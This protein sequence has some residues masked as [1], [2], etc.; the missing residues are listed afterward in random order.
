M[1]DIYEEYCKCG[2]Q[3]F[4]GYPDDKLP[5]RCIS[6]K[7]EDM[8]P[9]TGNICQGINKDGSPCQSFASLGIDK[10]IFCSIHAD[11]GMKNLNAKKCI[12]CNGSIASLGKFGDKPEYCA[13][14][15]PN[16]TE[17]IYIYKK[18]CIGNCSRLAEIGNEYCS[19]CNPNKEAYSHIKE[20]TVKKYFEENLD[21]NKFIMVHNK[22]IM[23]KNSVRP[24]FL[25]I[26]EDRIIIVEVD[27]EQHKR[28]GYSKQND[29][30]RMSNITNSLEFM[31]KK[32]IFI[33]YNPDKYTLKSHIIE[34]DDDKRLPEL[35]K[36]L[37]QCS[38]MNIDDINK[39]KI[40]YIYYDGYQFGKP[41]IK[42]Y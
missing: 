23:G 15:V 37:I 38:E 31:K 16:R 5:S 27:E 21:L 34:S 6:C 33:R 10:I 39:I 29:L 30:T 8:V 11:E 14:C 1:I 32:V 22:T 12:K 13:G 42:N 3:S 20:E 4:Y 2:I 41:V 19:T 9:L 40:Y 35:K 36:I 28:G 17:Y 24:D 25:F 7:D 18:Y 26:F